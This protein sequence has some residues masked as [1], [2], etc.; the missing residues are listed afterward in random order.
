MLPKD[1]INYIFRLVNCAEW[2]EKGK[3]MS[4]FKRLGGDKPKKNKSKSG[5]NQTS[6]SVTQDKGSDEAKNPHTTTDPIA[7]DK[8][9]FDTAALDEIDRRLAANLARYEAE[10]SDDV[11]NLVRNEDPSQ[12]G[13]E[14]NLL[15]NSRI[16][17]E[18]HITQEEL[19][20]TETVAAT[21][22]DIGHTSSSK[23]DNGIGGI[24]F[25]ADD[26]AGFTPPEVTARLTRSAP[27]I[28][29]SGSN[30]SH[31]QAYDT[32]SNS[33]MAEVRLDIARISSDIESGEALYRRAQTRVQNLLGFVEEAEVGFSQ[34]N[35]LEPENRRLKARNLTLAKEFESSQGKIAVLQTKY[36]EGERRLSEVRATLENTQS[37]LSQTSNELRKRDEELKSI[38]T[39]ATELEL[40]WERT[41]N[42]HDVEARE[43]AILRQ[44]ITALS[45]AAEDAMNEK[46]AFAKMVE[47]LKVD[48]EDQ[49]NIKDA[50]EREVTDLR[51][52]LHNAE[53]QNAEMKSQ[54]MAVH[55]EIKAF[56]T[57]YEF[58]I[59]TRDDRIFALEAQIE[60]LSK[61]IRIKDEIVSSAAQDVAQLR[62]AR[63]A[64]DLERERLEKVIE[65]QTYQLDSAQD[66]LLR[67]KQNIEEL[68]N[69]YRDAASALAMTQQRRSVKTPIE[70]PDIYPQMQNNATTDKSSLHDDLTNSEVEDR[71]MDFKLGLRDSIT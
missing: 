13:A 21:S 65:N 3:N 58:N 63:T 15:E 59:I 27:H 57:E 39:R 47:S 50:S 17:S 6:K 24:K 30:Y 14:I 64:Q 46:I 19:A 9:P 29:V 11:K 51:H 60:D 37:R 69:R 26:L 61:Q 43:N 16:K 36:E 32:P 28:D 45:G 18:D 4:L 49:R 10:V 67:S 35:R 54:L 20:N 34:L 7:D 33:E 38:S 48:F 40:Q 66:Q 56:K 62:K 25:V 12:K 68:D 44:K 31:A 5:K 2:D 41:K 42:N 70:N 23:P 55:G 53:T 71:I 1:F 8:K 52:A 22:S